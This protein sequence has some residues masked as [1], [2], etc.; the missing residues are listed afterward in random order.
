MQ[1]TKGSANMRVVESSEPA[2]ASLADIRKL[3]AHNLRKEQFRQSC[4]NSPV[5]GSWLGGLA[6]QMV[7]RG[8]PPPRVLIQ[9][10]R[11]RI[12][13]DVS[14]SLEPDRTVAHPHA[15]KS[16]HSVVKRAEALI[17]MQEATHEATFVTP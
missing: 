12:F 1:Q 17:R 16:R 9:S 11:I 15:C 7:N 14:E 3:P 2:A 6:D 10:D 5:A 8:G 13:I 4:Q